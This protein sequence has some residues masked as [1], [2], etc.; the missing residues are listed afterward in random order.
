MSEATLS[1]VLGPTNTG[2]TRL[3]IERMIAHPSGMIGLP[4]RLLAREVYDRVVEEKG[5]GAAALMTGEERIVPP[6]AR[7]YVCTVEAMP[8]SRPVDFLAIDE[9]Q[10]CSDPD[11][12]HVFTD[13]VLHARGRHETMLLG[14]ETARPLLRKL[15]PDA[16]HD[17]RERLSTLTH[18]GSCK[19]TKLPRRTAI[20][21]FSSEDV[22]A[23]AELMR[24]QRGGA[25]VVMGALSPATRN[26]QVQL[27]QDGEVDFLVATDAIGMGLNMDVDHVAF[28]SLC[29]YDGHRMRLL[30]ADELAQIAGRAGRY[31]R[32]GSFGVT[33]DAPELRDDVIARIENHRFD[34]L[35]K[36][37]WRN[38][39]L[40]FSSLDALERSLS[41]PTRIEGLTRTR[42]ALDHLTLNALIDDVV[43]AQRA[44][45]DSD[46]IQR[47]WSVCQLPDFRKTTMD[48]HFGLV[49][50][51]INALT[52]NH[53]VLQEAYLAGQIR[54]LDDTSGDVDILSTRL[55]HM[56]TWAYVAQRRDWLEDTSHW[57]EQTA[58]IE[59]RLSEALHERLTQRFVD[60]R[61][62]TLLRALRSRDEMVGAVQRDGTVL[63]DGFRVGTLKGLRF[64]P[65]DRGRDLQA[66]TARN[67]AEK[68]VRPEIDQRLT[69]LAKCEAAALTLTDEGAIRWQDEVI[70]KLDPGPHRLRPVVKLMGGELGQAVLAR[71]AEHHIQTLIQAHIA[72]VLEV[73]VNWERASQDVE[74]GPSGNARGLLFHLLEHEGAAERHHVRDIMALVEK[75]D[76]RA[77]RQLGVYFGEYTIFAPK[78]LKPAP[79]RLNAILRAVARSVP[80]QLPPMGGEILIPAEPKVPGHAY[81]AIGFRLC[82]TVAV[83]FDLLERLADALREARGKDGRF[84]L[85]TP[86]RALLGTDE[87]T[88][89]SILTALGYRR[90]RQGSVPPPDHYGPTMPES[91]RRLSAHEKEARAA[92]KHDTRASKSGVKDTQRPKHHKGKTAPMRPQKPRKPAEP[93]IDPNSPFAELAQW[94][95]ERVAKAKGKTR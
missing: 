68:T 44:G 75:E 83:R 29:K 14:S 54:G 23:I 78:L 47:M 94:Q 21:A 86:L 85:L 9:V 27:Y 11:R 89:K 56:R 61:T 80:V 45:Q 5:V 87:E 37:Q 13:R 88:L 18:Q 77:L 63:I 60:R 70:A 57:R 17:T 39:A 84:L 43:L 58:E 22:Y 42:D 50:S 76:R 15:L 73:L 31:L 25:A 46:I 10:L 7:F 26:A 55:A 35:K 69:Q 66:R 1:V 32:D 95:A 53:G 52:S 93:A 19:L 49:L 3:A 36:A 33:A 12:G 40:D 28:A 16:I 72:E 20:V 41:R 2:K 6:S 81:R 65:D 91:W 82:G 30:R 71:Q 51:L 64:Q 62:S 59:A 92:R 34:P 79:A 8:V 74:N 48:Q 67:V 4:L 24:R 90:A 38:S